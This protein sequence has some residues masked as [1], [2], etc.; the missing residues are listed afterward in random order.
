MYRSDQAYP[1]EQSTLSITRVAMLIILC[2]IATTHDSY[3]AEP[4]DESCSTNEICKSYF[5][6]AEESR[7]LAEAARDQASRRQLYKIASD[8]Y[9]K[10]YI[11]GK[12]HFPL[13][14]HC[15]ALEQ[16]SLDPCDAKNCYMNLSNIDKDNLYGKDIHASVKSC[17]EPRVDWSSPGSAIRHEG[18][19]LFL[20]KKTIRNIDEFEQLRNQKKKQISPHLYRMEKAGAGIVATGVVIGIGSFAAWFISLY[21]C[22]ASEAC[23]QDRDQTGALIGTFHHGLND[24]HAYANSTVIPAIMLTSAVTI[25][26]GLLISIPSYFNKK[27]RILN[28][29]PPPAM[30][31]LEPLGLIRSNQER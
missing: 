19:Q 9:A 25:G 20:V 15:F 5:D 13:Y 6:H 4:R 26:T 27:F 21:P 24:N 18:E 1:A 2:L 22:I 16:A 12:H 23:K 8:L 31:V 29:Q 10:A 11:E 28:Q 14:L 3:A 30:H 17:H 7:G